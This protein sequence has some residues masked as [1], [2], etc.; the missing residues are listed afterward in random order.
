VSGVAR[1]AAVGVVLLVLLLFVLVNVARGQGRVKDAKAGTDQAGSIVHGGLKRTYVLHVP[2]GFDK[3]RQWPLAFVLHGGGGDGS[4]VAKLTGFSGKADSAGFIVCYPDAVNHHWNDGR[5]VRR[6]KSQRDD[7]DDV[8]FI[9][10]LIDRFAKDLNVDPR[11]VYATGISNGGMMCHRLGCELSDRI[12]AIAPVAAA[13]PEP[14][15][16][17]LGTVPGFLPEI[18]GDSPRS[19]RRLARPVPVLAINGTRDPLVPYE[20]GGVGLYHKRGQVLSV[21]KTIEFW[22]VADSCGPKPEK[23]EIPDVDPHDGIKVV[24]ERY[25]RGRESSEVI[26]Y[27]VEGGGHT[28]PSGAR[29]VAR[30]GKTAR[31]IDATEVIWEFFAGH[32]R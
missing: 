5:Q 22:V 26:L 14:L 27:R 28:W 1:L 30:F 18:L 3:A 25:S 9:A 21:P 13:M 11:Y 4:K 12:A 29:R 7:I 16:Q 23:T 10:A 20:G 17:A 32:R 31:D 24:R 19:P 15:S 6:F 8:G 2:R